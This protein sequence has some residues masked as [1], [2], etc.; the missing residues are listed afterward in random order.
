MKSGVRFPTHMVR[1]ATK[2]RMAFRTVRPG[3][4]DELRRADEIAELPSKSWRGY[5][6]FEVTCRADFGAP[7]VGA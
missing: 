4:L 1:V 7:N 6:V 2:A 3:L 5:R